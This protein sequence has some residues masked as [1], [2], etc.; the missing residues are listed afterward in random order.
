[1]TPQQTWRSLAT[2]LGWKWS[3]ADDGW[4]N[5]N[6]MEAPG[7]GFYSEGYPNYIVKQTVEDCC[8]LD[9]FETLEQAEA[10]LRKRW[11]AEWE[12]LRPHFLA[13]IPR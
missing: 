6:H 2:Q 9:G 3:S 10:E 5:G 7:K 1:M 11:A 8:F 13:Y 4:I 12:V